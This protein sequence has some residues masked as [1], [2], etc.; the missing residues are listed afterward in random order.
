MAPI[1]Q[2][3]GLRRDYVMGSSIVHALDGLDLEVD[4]GEFLCIMGPSGSGK[5]TLLNL[6]GGL[7]RPTGGSLIVGGE[8][9]QTLDE[10]ALAAYRRRR[11]GFVFQSFNLVATMSALQNVEFPTLFARTPAK[12]RRARAQELLGRVGLGE[13]ATHKPVELSGGEQQRVAIA[14]ALINDPAILLCDEPTGNLDT[15]TGREVMSLLSDTNHEGRT[16]LVVTHDP[17]VARFASR[18]IRLQDGQLVRDEVGENAAFV[19][20]SKQP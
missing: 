13:R 6:V 9:L 18:I 15:H 8:D 2:A 20:A 14:R 12:A 3:I 4:A 19:V 7:D 1:I 16:L 10:D 11:V 17:N 5:S